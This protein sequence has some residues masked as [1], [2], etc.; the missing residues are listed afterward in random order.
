MHHTLTVA[1]S[2]SRCVHLKQQHPLL[3][4]T[5]QLRA[6]TMASL[7]CSSQPHVCQSTCCCDVSPHAVVLNSRLQVA[8]HT[9]CEL[10]QLPSTTQDPTHHPHS[11]ASKQNSIITTTRSASVRPCRRKA[12]IHQGTEVRKPHP[13]C[14]SSSWATKPWQAWGQK[15]LTKSGGLDP[16]HHTHQHGHCDHPAH[17]STAQCYCYLPNHRTP[18]GMRKQR[19]IVLAQQPPP[20]AAEAVMC[21]R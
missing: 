14:T 18:S 21:Q 2:S 7:D 1:G 12:F 13:T 6:V 20:P 8:N 16:C 5:A 11:T 19:K 17:P 9:S 15:P 3:A 4:V 10:T